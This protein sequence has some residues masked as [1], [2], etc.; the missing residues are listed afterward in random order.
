M[1]QDVTLLEE[2]AEQDLTQTNGGTTGTYM[3][4]VNMASWYL[5]NQG[6]VCTATKECQPNCNQ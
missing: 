2:L 4:S 3:F 1:H 6:W 5:G